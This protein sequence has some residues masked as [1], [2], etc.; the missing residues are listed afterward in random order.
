ME[1]VLGEIEWE[2]ERVGC[3]E[4]NIS[5]ER[6]YAQNDNPGVDGYGVRGSVS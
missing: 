1:D 2:E 6:G 3:G 5:T 4:G